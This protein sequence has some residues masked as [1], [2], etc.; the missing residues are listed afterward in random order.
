MSND[1]SPRPSC[2]TTIGTRGLTLTTFRRVRGDREHHAT[3]CATGAR[4]AIPPLVLALRGRL[5]GEDGRSGEEERVAALVS[6]LLDGAAD[7]RSVA[8]LGNVTFTRQGPAGAPS[9]LLAAHMDELGFVVQHVEDD[10][11]LRLAP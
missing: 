8:P 6:T 3:P 5:A 9:V 7:A 4:S 1:R 10:G 2:C 11:M